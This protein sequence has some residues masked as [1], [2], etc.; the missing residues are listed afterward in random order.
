MGTQFLLVFSKEEILIVLSIFTKSTYA[1][2][3]NRQSPPTQMDSLQ[4]MRLLALVLQ[5]WAP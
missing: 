3:I 5:I 1:S 4:H 2:I